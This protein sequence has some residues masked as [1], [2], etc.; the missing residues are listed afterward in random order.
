MATGVSTVIRWIGILRQICHLQEIWFQIGPRTCSCSLFIWFCM[1]CRRSISLLNQKDGLCPM[2]FMH[3]LLCHC[4]ALSSQKILLLTNPSPSV[5]GATHLP[6]MCHARTNS[7]EKPSCAL[8]CS[9]ALLQWSY[10]IFTRA[11]FKCEQREWS[12]ILFFYDAY[13]SNIVYYFFAANR[14]CLI[15]GFSS[16]PFVFQ[17]IFRLPAFSRLHLYIAT[18]QAISFLQS[19]PQEKAEENEV[20]TVFVLSNLLRW[21]CGSFVV[22][23]KNVVED[24]FLSAWFT[25]QPKNEWQYYFLERAFPVPNFPLKK[26]WETN[27]CQLDSPCNP[28]A[29]GNIIFWNALFLCLV[30][31]VASKPLDTE[32]DSCYGKILFQKLSRLISASPPPYFI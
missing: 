27:F 17:V 7:G 14:F 32:S 23:V 9:I 22:S 1:C 5:Y 10:S 2:Y 13:H 15:C 28:R 24:T 29:N 4:G 30:S 19:I 25:L 31:K 26:L 12:S 21:C 6:Y 20:A 18:T 16:F 3:R 11:R 8:T